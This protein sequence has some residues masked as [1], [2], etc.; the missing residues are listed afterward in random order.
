MVCAPESKLSV[1]TLKANQLWGSATQLENCTRLWYLDIEVRL[2]G[3]PF[4]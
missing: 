1:V 3:G 2:L 4:L